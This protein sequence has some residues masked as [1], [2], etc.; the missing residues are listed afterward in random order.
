MADES[1]EDSALDALA[2]KGRAARE[3][4]DRKKQEAAAKIEA[5]QSDSHRKQAAWRLSPLATNPLRFVFSI[6]FWVVWGVTL[7]MAF[8]YFRFF[9][10]GGHPVHGSDKTGS[11]WVLDPAKDGYALFYVFLASTTIVIIGIVWRI[12]AKRAGSRAFAAETAWAE[13]APFTV[14]GYP[15]AVG[16][17]EHRYKLDIYFTGRIPSRAKF[18][19][20][21]RGVDT[22]IRDDHHGQYCRFVADYPRDDHPARNAQRFSRA[23]HA[24]VEQVLVAMK[25]ECPVDR[26]EVRG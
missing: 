10:N 8:P 6:P 14:L 17:D 20:V 19:D 22:D 7:M 12:L 18:A 25:D 2:E 23:F 4:E 16:Q 5:E 26:I 1:G 9:L 13:A 21:M 15:A 3:A 11:R 24:I